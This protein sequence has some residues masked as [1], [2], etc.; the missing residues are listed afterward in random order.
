MLIE[1]S[2]EN[3]RSFKDKKTLNLIASA[4]KELPNNIFKAQIKGEDVPPLLKST[5]IYGANASGK[6]NLIR[7][8]FEMG[9]FIVNTTSMT[10]GDEINVT[11]FLLNKHS[12]NKP[13]IFEFIFIAEG[14]RYQYGYSATKVRVEE[15][16]LI[17]YPLGRPQKWINRAINPS[18][19]K[20][21]IKFGEHLL[22]PNSQKEQYHKLTRDNELVL[23]KAIQLNSEHLKPV[24]N[25]FKKY[26]WVLPQRPFYSPAT[27]LNYMRKNDVAINRLVNLISSADVGIV[28]FD[29]KAKKFELNA[30]PQEVRK[31]LKGGLKNKAI[32]SKIG[33]SRIEVETIYSIHRSAD[34]DKTIKFEFEEES[35]G[36]RKL[37]TLAGYILNCLE[38]GGILIIDELNSSMHPMM[39]EYIIKLFSNSSTNIGNGQLIFSTHDTTQLDNTLF[40]R[41]QI[42]FTE[43]S[44]DGSS[45]L[46]P[47]SNFSP[48]KDESLEKGYLRGKYGAIPYLGEFKF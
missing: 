37:F 42:W 12:Q 27:T 1:F 8:A 3:Y 21:T 26:L 28:G 34:S 14:V 15:E 5:A 43:R 46:Y 6:S 22:D 36:T 19:G 18:T 40:R 44:K 20:S 7:A 31:L 10:E 48:R 29:T 41:D 4:G 39:V 2:V 45:D 32:V 25:W 11:P 13:S 33:K 47:L 23:S 9:T 35:D 17:A 24:Y 16:W 30:L 38:D